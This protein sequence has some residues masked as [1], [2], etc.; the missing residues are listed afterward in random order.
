MAT[1][2]LSLEVSDTSAWVFPS[3]LET[4]RMEGEGQLRFGKAAAPSLI[5]TKLL[6]RDLP[7]SW[8]CGI[9]SS[10]ELLQVGLC[11]QATGIAAGLGPGWGGLGCDQQAL[12]RPAAW[13]S[14]PTMGIFC[15][16]TPRTL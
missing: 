9:P 14:T 2:G 10:T 8:Y 16:T 13:T 12:C 6:A 3:K 7:A 4:W 15:W 1:C 5:Y 11:G